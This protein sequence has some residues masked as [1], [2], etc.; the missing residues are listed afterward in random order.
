MTKKYSTTEVSKGF[1]IKLVTFHDW[2]KRNFISPTDESG[3]Q[4]QKN[5]FTIKDLYMIRFFI[6]LMEKGFARQI[7]SEISKAFRVALDNEKLTGKKQYAVIGI[8]SNGDIKALIATDKR[9]LP[10]SFL[11]SNFK[12]F[13]IMYFFK[14]SKIIEDVK[15]IF[16]E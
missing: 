14:I 12:K 13:E 8:K 10:D 9:K 5:L 11:M 6:I 1:D 16:K 3:G 7:A 4:G 2:I 15:N